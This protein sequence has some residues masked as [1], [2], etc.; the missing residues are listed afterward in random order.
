MTMS[1]SLVRASHKG[2][3]DHDDLKLQGTDETLDSD[4]T[5]VN[6]LSQGITTPRV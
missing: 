4:G 3:H 5:T 1:F 6:A 2:D